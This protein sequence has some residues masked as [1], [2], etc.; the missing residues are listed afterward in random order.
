MEAHYRQNL[1]KRGRLGTAIICAA[2]VTAAGLCWRRP[3]GLPNFNPTAG[4]FSNVSPVLIPAGQAP[5]EVGEAGPY[6]STVDSSGLYG[7]V[8]KATVTLRLTHAF[9]DDVDMLLVGPNGQRLIL[10]SQAGGG[11]PVNNVVLTFDDAAPSLLPNASQ[12]ISGAYKPTNYGST[13]EPFPPPAPGP[14]FATTL[15][16]FNALTARGIEGRPWDAGIA[17]ALMADGFSSRRVVG[18]G[19]QPPKPSGSSPS[20][21]NSAPA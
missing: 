1:C 11:G 12:I 16:A 5:P 7:R 9:P 17:A 2:A 3:L 13:T 8:A 19:E 10:M 21:A 6:P 14:P 4:E 20:A 15:A 18:V